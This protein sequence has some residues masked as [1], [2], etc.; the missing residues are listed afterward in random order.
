MIKINGLQGFNGRTK[1]LKL[2][3]YI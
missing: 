2:L 3:F 1:P